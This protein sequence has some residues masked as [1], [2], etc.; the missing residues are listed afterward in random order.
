M[1]L[2]WYLDFYYPFLKK[3][4]DRIRSILPADK[5]VFLEPI[6]NEVCASVGLT[7]HS[8]EIAVLSF[9]HHR[10]PQINSYPTWFSY[11]TGKQTQYNY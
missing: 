2:D 7:M 1:Q 3:W 11:P 4:D 5:L 10:G 8:T 6:P 9:A